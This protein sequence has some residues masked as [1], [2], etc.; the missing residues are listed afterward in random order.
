G[1]QPPGNRMLCL[2]AYPD[3]STGTF[4]GSTIQLY[5]DPRSDYGNSN[6]DQ[7]NIF[8]SSIVYILPF[9]RG[10]RF[11]RDVS[12]PMDWLIGGWQTNLIGFVASG[13][14]FD[15]STSIAQPGN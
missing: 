15:L 3:D 1:R 11:G 5:Y 13:Q 7:R 10:Q 9:G 4:T 6:Q 8:S 14:A 12:R 2:V